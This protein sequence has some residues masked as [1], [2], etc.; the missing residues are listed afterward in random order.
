MRFFQKKPAG[1][2]AEKD[3]ANDTSN[4]TTPARTPP[5]R[6]SVQDVSVEEPKGKV[7]VIAGI[8]GAVA[9]IGGFMFGYES[10]Q[11]SGFLA[12]SDF[13]D[14]FSEN[15]EFTAVRQG[16]IVGLLWYIGKPTPLS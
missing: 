12:M 13:I 14:R 7:P 4:V 11:I 3:T 16:T 9:S 15:G 6:S 10:G 1:A 2:L 8:L 5:R